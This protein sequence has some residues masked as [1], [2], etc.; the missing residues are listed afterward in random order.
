MKREYSLLFV[1]LFVLAATAGT[2]WSIER[3]D[4]D[5][6]YGGR[7]QNDWLWG[8]SAEDTVDEAFGEVKAD[9]E[10]RRVRAYMNGT[11]YERVKFM[12]DM[13]FAGG[14][15]EFKEM[16]M[17]INL[18][19]KNLTEVES[20]QEVLIT[21][22]NIPD[23][24]IIG[25]VS[26]LSPVVSSETRTFQGKL[27][28]DNPELKLRPGMFVKADIVVTRKDS[29][30]VVPKD[31]IISGTRG[32]TVFVVDRSAARERRIETGIENVEQVEVVSGLNVNDQLV[33]SGYETLRNGSR[34]NVIQ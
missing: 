14:D 3:N 32:R 25:V 13:D 23:D 8:A 20:G 12:F 29:V 2:A 21:N 5:L 7:I 22:Y 9:N 30:I 26:E 16:Y 33:I 11:L 17:E 31:V 28:I 10:F 15:V 27:M 4:L 1:A 6:K 24:T 34:V 18:P 19:E